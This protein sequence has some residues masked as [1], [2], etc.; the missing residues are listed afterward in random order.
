MVE[1]EERGKDK[2]RKQ[3]GGR[4]AEKGGR[5]GERFCRIVMSGGSG[6]GV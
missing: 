2:A 4:R 3:R 5:G 1:M 6:H